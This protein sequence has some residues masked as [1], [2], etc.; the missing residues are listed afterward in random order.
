MTKEGPQL[1]G[2]I[3]EERHVLGNWCPEKK[4]QHAIHRSLPRHPQT[5]GLAYR[6]NYGSMV[7]GKDYCRRVC[8]LCIKC[9]QLAG[10]PH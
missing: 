2:E 7:K 10:W 8:H 3:A 5:K 9:P 6:G 4:G 1:L